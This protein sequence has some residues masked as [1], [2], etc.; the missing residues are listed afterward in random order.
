MDG[1]TGVTVGTDV[2]LATGN[3]TTAPTI[4]G[5]RLDGPQDCPRLSPDGRS[6]LFLRERTAKHPEIMLSEFPDGRHAHPVTEGY[7]PRWLPWDKGF[8][9]SPDGRRA[10]VFRFDRGEAVTPLSA[11][12]LEDRTSVRAIAAEESKVAVLSVSTSGSD[13]IV[14]FH[15][16]ASPR[17][18]SAW[19]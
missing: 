19:P 15:D 13:A 10:A 18:W 14:D 16:G 17:R 11:P 7:Y 6:L 12:K 4:A 2:D 3:T 8:A 5:A 9:F 1:G